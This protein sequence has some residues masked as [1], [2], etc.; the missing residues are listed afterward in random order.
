MTYTT[1]QTLADLEDKI[2]GL[3]TTLEKLSEEIAAAKA[4][5]KDMEV[6]IKQASEDREAENKEFQEEVTDQ[7]MMQAILQKALERLAKVYDKAG[8]GNFLQQ[9][10]PQKF[11][12]YKQN[13]GS[14]PVMGLIEQIIEDSKSVETDAVAGEKEAQAAYEEFV[15]NSSDSITALNNAIQAKSD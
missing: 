9:A 11:Q 7:R 13:A 8:K 4:E 14:S 15:Q 1:K 5:I 2:A 6:A 12:P 10:P 3:T